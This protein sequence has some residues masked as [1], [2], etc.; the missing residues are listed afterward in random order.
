MELLAPVIIVLFS[1]TG[2][3]AIGAGFAWIAW[4]VDRAWRAPGLAALW[5]GSAAVG[6]C[7]LAVWVHARPER[8]PSV[9]GRAPLTVGF[10]LLLTTFGAAAAYVARHRQES[11]RP[12]RA[13]IVEAGA[14][15]FWAGAGFTVV[16]IIVHE[17]LA[18]FGT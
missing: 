6:A 10:P 18:R 11:A 16:L 13:V 8:P 2:F 4:H 15:H 9:S 14:A 5:V 1:L 7:L 17:A 3:F 12:P